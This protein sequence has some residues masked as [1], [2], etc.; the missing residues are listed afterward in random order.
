M[1]G[2]G[3]VSLSTETTG[4]GGGC[5]VRVPR[6]LPQT[7]R[8]RWVAEICRYRVR[9][10]GRSYWTGETRMRW[11]ERHVTY[12]GPLP[13]KPKRFE[14]HFYPDGDIQIAIAEDFSPPRLILPITKDGVELRGKPWPM[15]TPEQMQSSEFQGIGI[16]EGDEVSLEDGE[17][18]R[19]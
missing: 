4:G 18:E 9:P 6:S 14:V 19:G 8:V 5:C 16:W 1:A 17:V 10:K 3:N 7:Y 11:A 2:G 15:C 12:H 13:A